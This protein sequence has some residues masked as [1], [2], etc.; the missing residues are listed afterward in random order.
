MLFRSKAVG[1]A[2][3]VGFGVYNRFRLLPR[4]DESGAA[5]RLSRSVKT[6]VA[7]VIVVI[8]LGG[9]LAYTPTPPKP[10]S[11]LSAFTG[12]SQ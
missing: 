1:L 9:F 8:L 2:I 5:G 4:I 7:V 6:E 12:R 10:Q 3:L 11:L